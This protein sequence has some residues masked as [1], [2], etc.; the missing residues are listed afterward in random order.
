MSPSTFKRGRRL[1]A[2][3]LIVALLAAPGPDYRQIADKAA[4]DGPVHDGVEIQID[5]PTGQ[6]VRNFGAPVDNKGLCVF[7]S[8]TMAG[9]WHNVRSLFDVIHRINEGGERCLVAPERVAQRMQVARMDGGQGRQH[10]VDALAH[11]Q[12]GAGQQIEATSDAAVRGG[13]RRITG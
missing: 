4:V 3:L 13:S 8:M 6:H 10:R 12:R 1:L 11:L 9:R 5:L 2:P 7:A